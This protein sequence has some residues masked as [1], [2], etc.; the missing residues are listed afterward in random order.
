M[1]GTVSYLVDCSS[2]QGVPDWARVAGICIGGA[3][4]VAEGTTYVNPDWA[5]SKAGLKAV[6]AHGFVPLAYM[7]MDAAG[8]GAAQARNFG[9]HAGD[10]SGFGIVIDFERA[11][12]GP[13]TL[14]QARDCAAEI[15]SLY[16]G[17]PVGGYAPKWYTGG[18]DLSW[19][20]W[21]WA[22]DFVA[23]S[24]DPG[25]LYPQVPATWWAPYG[26]RTPL[27]LQFTEEGTVAGISG[28]VDCSAFHGDAA[29]LASHV[30]R[31]APSAPVPSAA[32]QAAPSAR[33]GD[34]AMLIT[35]APGDSPVTLPVWANA[36]GYH[37]TPDYSR[38]SLIFTGG[39]GAVMKATL[40]GPKTPQIVTA[41]L[42][43]GKAWTV[44]P[45][46]TWSEYSVIELQRL[47][48]R[49]GVPAS[50]TFRTW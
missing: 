18:E 37:E 14:A 23:G 45:M 38:C 21:L 42:T 16:P 4:K 6:A 36:G 40:Y 31:P 22:S 3:E 32:A 47:D 33:P 5:A 9:S 1:T 35:F 24:G 25:M 26:G 20:D 28:K 39:T 13:P 27:L 15:R 8:S 49:K 44:F 41:S 43:A 19:C 7:F 17:I 10:L 11:P 2:Y 46:S 34:D 29:Q 12:D 48:T 30:L 50:A